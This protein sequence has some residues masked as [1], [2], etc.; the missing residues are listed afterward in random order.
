[1]DF[2]FQSPTVEAKGPMFNSTCLFHSKGIFSLAKAFHGYVDG[3]HSR[4]GGT[5]AVGGWSMRKKEAGRDGCWAVGC[6]EEGG[7]SRWWRRSWS[8]GHE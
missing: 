7:G 3:G 4:G 2:A 5:R 1:M 6:G 8:R